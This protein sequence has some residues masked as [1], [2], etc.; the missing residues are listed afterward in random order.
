MARPFMFAALCQCVRPLKHSLAES[1]FV[2]RVRKTAKK[3]LL[4]EK[5]ISRVTRLPR[6][7]CTIICKV[8]ILAKVIAHSRTR[9]AVC[10]DFD[11]ASQ[12]V[13][14]RS[15]LSVLVKKYGIIQKNYILCGDCLRQQKSMKSSLL[16]Q[17]ESLLAARFKHHCPSYISVQGTLIREMVADR[18]VHKCMGSNGLIKSFKRRHNTAYSTLTYKSR[19]VGS[20]TV[21]DRNT[22]C[23]L[24]FEHKY[25]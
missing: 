17:R 19:G 24:W 7:Q 6:Y 14:S 10:T 21:Y 13:L 12:L 25:G 18:G 22:T 20:E 5:L 4:A 16:E 9:S 3:S 8:G 15:T 1:I 23:S 2:S 11:V